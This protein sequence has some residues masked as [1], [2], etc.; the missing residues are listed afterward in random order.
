M[1]VTLGSAAR[2]QQRSDGSDDS[3]QHSDSEV[4]LHKHVARFFVQLDRLHIR[5]LAIQLIGQLKFDVCCLHIR[6][7]KGREAYK[8]HI[9]P[10][11]RCHGYNFFRTTGV[12][13]AAA[14]T[15][16][17]NL[18]AQHIQ[19]YGERGKDKSRRNLS[20]LII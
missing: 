3:I 12:A 15:A 17:F 5:V 13:A 4:Y 2:L 20:D 9:S 18:L 14:T 1:H 11:P 7:K 16:L 10:R 6:G 19:V 8:S